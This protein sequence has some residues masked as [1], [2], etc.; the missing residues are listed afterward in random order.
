MDIWCK[1]LMKLSKRFLYLVHFFYIIENSTILLVKKEVFNLKLICLRFYRIHK[2]WI[3]FI[4]NVSKSSFKITKLNSTFSPRKK[5]G[6]Q[7]VIF[8]CIVLQKFCCLKMMVPK[9]KKKIKNYLY[10]K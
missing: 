8:N 5:V 10:I 7:F 6:C 9:S 2:L 1:K 3:F 4:T